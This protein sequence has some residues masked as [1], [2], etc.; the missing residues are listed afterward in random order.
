MGPKVETKSEGNAGGT[1]TRSRTVTGTVT[2]ASTSAVIT[3]IT[4]PTPAA[5]ITASQPA[6]YIQHAPI[7]VHTAKLDTRS[8]EKIQE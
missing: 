4:T 3:P 1:H 8:F 2:P 7:S 5:P 6:Y